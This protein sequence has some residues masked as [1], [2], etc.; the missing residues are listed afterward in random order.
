MARTLWCKKILSGRSKGISTVVGTVFLMLIIF[1]VAAN[2]ILWSFTQ[3]AEYN[4]AVM[5]KNEEEAE[6]HNENVVAS[7]GEYSVDGDR[8][9]LETMLTNEGSVAARMVNLWVL[10]T[11]IQ[12]YGYNDTI[13][14]MSLNPGDNRAVSAVVT[15]PG[16]GQGHTFSSWFLTARGNT[17]PVEEN[18]VS[19]FV[20]PHPW[21]DMGLIRFR[22]EYESL[23][24]TSH[25]YHDPL[26]GWIVPGLPGGAP[27]M[28]HVRII[29]TGKVPVTLQKYCVFYAMEYRS[30]QGGAAQQSY[31][32][33]IVSP[34][35]A[36]PVKKPVQ[37]AMFPY[38]EDTNPYV[39]QPNPEEK[40]WL[41]GPPVVIKFAAKSASGDTPMSLS[42]NCEYLAFIGLYYSY[43]DDGQE[44][45]LG[46]TIPFVAVRSVSPYSPPPGML[47][48][49][50]DD[51]TKTD[52][53]RI[54]TNPYLDAIDYDSNYVYAVG[55]NRQGGDFGFIDSGRSMG[56]IT[57]VKV[58]VYATNDRV[59]DSL[60]VFVWD[61]ST[62]T[63]LGRQE[64]PTSWEWVDWDATTILDT[65]TKIDEAKM[66]FISKPNPGPNTITVD[67]AR[68]AVDWGN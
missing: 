11:T 2:V 60:E 36:Y 41:G 55:N 15:I 62:W 12:R 38:D 35:S 45:Q 53:V 68:L 16:A 65:W 17:V 19:E 25:S 51:E 57:S 37:E 44:R 54:G 21:I 40:W 50:A 59:G 56:T 43:I 27:I 64:I 10:D 6:R 7:D 47:Y 48:V 34:D 58:Q 49:N 52:W 32:F 29:N 18:I 4:E 39:L 46:Q 63:S 61:G 14:W 1:M 13:E 23:N 3:N 5:A 31:P 42:S 9:T 30:G 26:P 66:Y 33:Y 28:F 24:F 22:F 67:C 20:E 8:V